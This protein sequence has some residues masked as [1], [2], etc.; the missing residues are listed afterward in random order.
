MWVFCITIEDKSSCDTFFL[1]YCKKYYKLP[2]LD[3]LDM[4]GHFHQKWQCQLVET[5]TF[6]SMQKINFISIFFFFF[7]DIVK[8]LQTYYFGNF[9]NAWPSPSKITVPICRKLSSLSTFK[10]FI[11]HLRYCKEIANLIFWVIWACLV[12]HT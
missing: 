3:T 5:L 1:K 10:K 8:T 6:I 7:W 12:T 11:T 2:I 4:S 9:W